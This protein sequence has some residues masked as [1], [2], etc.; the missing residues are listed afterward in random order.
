MSG[1]RIERLLAGDSGQLA[2]ALVEGPQLDPARSPVL[3]GLTVTVRHLVEQP[4]AEFLGSEDGDGEDRSKSKGPYDTGHAGGQDKNHEELETAGRCDIA[5]S[6]GG[7]WWASL[8]WLYGLPCVWDEEAACQLSLTGMQPTARTR[9]GT[10]VSVALG[11]LRWLRLS[12]S[13]E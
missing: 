6:R 5:E 3:V 13:L 10:H 2:V 1:R 4:R 12:G 7:D 11:L 8:V 9:R